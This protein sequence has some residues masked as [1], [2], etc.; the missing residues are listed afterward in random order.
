MRT[1]PLAFSV[2][3]TLRVDRLYGWLPTDPRQLKGFVEYHIMRRRKQWT[4][5]LE[6]P[7]VAT[8]IAEDGT[9]GEPQPAIVTAQRQMVRI[10]RKDGTMLREV[11]YEAEVERI[12]EALK[13][14]LPPPIPV[15][16]RG[17]G[18]GRGKQPRHLPVT[19][20]P[21][22]ARG[23]LYLSPGSVKGLIKEVMK[24]FGVHPTTARHIV[25]PITFWPAKLTLFRGPAWRQGERATLQKPDGLG[26]KTLVIR[27]MFGNK[28]SALGFAEHV[29]D[30]Y[31]TFVINVP[32]RS[33]DRGFDEEYL[34]GCLVAGSMIGFGKPFEL[35]RGR[36]SIEE[37][38]PS[39]PHVDPVRL[40]GAQPLAAFA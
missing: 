22:S 3:V 15:E 18:R 23:A 19:A 16:T 25:S 24:G 29:D 14:K 37:Y 26:E 1:P 10:T 5:T 40:E 36:Y 27:D 6:L 17:P 30:V 2:R 32:Q 31:L 11:P 8:A 9:V 39:T 33:A 20:F 7:A 13:A 4:E 38:R 28:S 34:L 12:V 21:F 35:H